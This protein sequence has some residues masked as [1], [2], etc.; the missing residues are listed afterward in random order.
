MSSFFSIF[1]LPIWNINFYGSNWVENWRQHILVNVSFWNIFSLVFQR[2]F[3]L[4]IFTEYF[5]FTGRCLPRK[6]LSV[7]KI[8]TFLSFFKVP[9]KCQKLLIDSGVVIKSIKCLL[10]NFRKWITILKMNEIRISWS[11]MEWV[12]NRIFD[13][14][15][16]GFL[17]RHL[18]F[19]ILISCAAYGK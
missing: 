3:I 1:L 4:W 19:I 16:D 7:C 11:F 14:I 12:F 15:F 8:K 13:G 5:L 17:E 9:M 6:T 2:F 18:L 10:S